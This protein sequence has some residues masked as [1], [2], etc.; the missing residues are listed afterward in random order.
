MILIDKLGQT[1]SL[2]LVREIVECFETFLHRFI[3]KTES[4]ELWINSMHY[5]F[6]SFYI[7]NIIY[8]FIY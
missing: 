4:N 8:L 7:L 6:S 2:R 3:N 5:M 1:S